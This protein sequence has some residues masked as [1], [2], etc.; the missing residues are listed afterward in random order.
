[1]PEAGTIAA[2]ATAPGRAGVA[3]IRVSGPDAFA[4]ARKVASVEPEP[5]RARF[6]RFRRAD[7]SPADEGLLLAFKEP[8]SYTGE[9]VVE[10]QCHGGAVAP[11]RV[12]EAAIAA[13][14]RLA[15]PGE[16]TR[17]AFLAGKISLDKAQSVID[18][19]DAMT[20]RAAD[21][22]LKDFAGRGNGALDRLY[23]DAIALSAEIEHAL[24]IDEGGLPRDFVPSIRLRIRALA[25]SARRAL[26]SA[27][28]RALLREG[29][30]V[31]LAG[32]PNAG[33][34]ALF[35]ALA[36]SSRAIVSD[37]PGTTRDF[38]EAWIDI[39]GWPV[40]L[41][42]TAGVRDCAAAADPVE[43]EGIERSKRLIENAEVAV[44]LRPADAPD[45]ETSGSDPRSCAG[46]TI[47]II[48]KCDLCPESRGSA[49]GLPRVSAA[50]GE[51]VGELKK[52][53]ADAL[54]SAADAVPRAGAGDG[55]LRER[56]AAALVSVCAALEE[57]LALPEDEEY[58]VFAGNDMRRVCETLAPLTDS[59]WTA[60]MIAALFSR[61]CV[62]K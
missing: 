54:E 26:H 7:G 1:M 28:E 34:S 21:A 27:R 44:E 19:I 45:G 59:N 23:R 24:D 55:V 51:G 29:A 18:L 41:V 15:G 16:F 35:N 48:S 57:S 38:I 33:K 39:D 46:T 58:L 25:E 47:R 2:V 6:A 22:A 4:I 17:R 42:D 31:V 49:G 13:G 43:R 36:G 8:A 12:L 20:P 52:L 30:S 56:G 11:R 53:I 40:R 5:G 60:D 9:D 37:I 10:F 50:T 3:V 32:P 62:G 14:A 61:F